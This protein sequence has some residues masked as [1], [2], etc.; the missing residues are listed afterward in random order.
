MHT[1]KMRRH[2]RH[3]DA[4]LISLPVCLRA[5]EAREERGMNV[6]DFIFIAPGEGW[7]EDFHE[8]GE[9]D[10]I[11]E[12]LVDEL[13]GEVFGGVAVVP[14]EVVERDIEG[15]GEGFE[16]GVIP[17]D[18]DGVGW[19]G[20]VGDG[21]EECGEAMGLFGDENGHFL[22]CSWGDVL[23]A[24]FHI[25][26]Y[27]QLLEEVMEVV[28]LE[29][30]GAPGCL[31]GHAEIAAGD[32]FLEGFDVGALLEEKLGDGGHHPTFVSANN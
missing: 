4:M 23:E 9:D 6:D 27:G 7:G 14:G 22:P 16:V 2:P 30:A 11:G 12:G 25:E 3:L 15:L 13:D 28:E 19:E 31:D 24:D 32:L 18:D 20:L 10:E 17:D 8:A 1:H 21:V 5:R 26:L 29:G